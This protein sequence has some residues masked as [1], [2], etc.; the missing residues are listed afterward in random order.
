MS[1]AFGWQSWSK[2]LLIWFTP[3]DALSPSA[4]SFDISLNSGS[5]PTITSPVPFVGSA[6]SLTLMRHGFGAGCLHSSTLP[7]FLVARGGIA[8]KADRLEM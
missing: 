7:R 6:I 4:R 1:G 3:M 2:P 5:L 8:K